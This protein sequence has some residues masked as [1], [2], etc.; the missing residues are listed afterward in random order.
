MR[1]LWRGRSVIGA[2]VLAAAAIALGA[3]EP[4]PAPSPGDTADPPRGELL[5]ATAGMQDPRFFHTVILLL[6]HDKDGALGIVINRPVG[7]RPIAELLTG[8]DG[9][10]EKNEDRDIEGTI[11]IFAGGPVQPELGFVVH[12]A[13]YRRD[14]TLDVDGQVAMT[15]SKEVLRDIG[16]HQGP[17][18]SLFA[19]GYAGWGAGQ[20]E[21]EMARHDWFTALDDPQLVFEEDRGDVWKRAL[22]R[23]M[24]EL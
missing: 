12:S 14:D 17:Q 15:A 22:A 8:S 19:L 4:A 11:K 5:I 6:R 7:E 13:E 2:A 3:A 20:L 18:K 23:R 21:A 24:R 16:H 1:W 10:A 9:K